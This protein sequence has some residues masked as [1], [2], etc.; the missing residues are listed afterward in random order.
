M[1]RFISLGLG[2][3]MVLL[4][5][6]HTQAGGSLNVGSSG[7]SGSKSEPG[8]DNLNARQ[9]V[10]VGKVKVLVPVGDGEHEVT[11]ME[12]GSCVW[13]YKGRQILCTEVHDVFAALRI[14]NIESGSA[15]DWTYRYGS[16]GASVVYMAVN[17]RTPNLY[18]Q[19]TTE[20]EATVKEL[21][22][23]VTVVKAKEV[24]EVKEVKETNATRESKPQ[25]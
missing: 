19:G 4:T 21:L 16:N 22:K 14:S 18:V 11:Q 9:T 1:S 7:S 12:D 24:K 5:V 23:L 3:L 6:S 8:S 25:K 13:E 15:G 2:L 10:T 17:K 20:N